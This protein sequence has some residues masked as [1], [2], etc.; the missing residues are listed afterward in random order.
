MKYEKILIAIDNSSCSMKAAKAG[1][2]LAHSLKATIGLI[3]VVDLKKEV[4]NPDL[5]ITQEQSQTVLLQEAENTIE[6][7]I[8]LYDGVNG[9]ERFTPEGFPAQEILNIAREWDADVIVMGTHGRSGLGKLITG[10]VAEHVIRH[11]TIPVLITPRN[12]A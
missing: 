2:S 12:I 5:G 1:F 9:I 10:S 3:Y 6:Q 7:Y 4:I 11:A 8:R